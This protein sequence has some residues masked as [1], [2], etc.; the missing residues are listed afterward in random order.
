[1]KRLNARARKA[2]SKSKNIDA[3]CI[4]VQTIVRTGNGVAWLSIDDKGLPVIVW[5]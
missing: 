2:I 5:R 3:R 4:P 1:M